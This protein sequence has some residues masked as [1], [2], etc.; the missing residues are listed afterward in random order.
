ML[1]TGGVLD[2]TNFGGGNPSEIP[3]TQKDPSTCGTVERNNG[4]RSMALFLEIEAKSG[5]VSLT[6][7]LL[8]L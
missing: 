2:E 8:F 6:V 5:T 7:P 3:K 1:T 4:L